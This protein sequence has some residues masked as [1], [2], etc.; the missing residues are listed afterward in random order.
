MSRSF[1]FVVVSAAWMLSALVLS[2]CGE[3]PLD[4]AVD[5]G[6]DLDHSEAIASGGDLIEGRYRIRGD[7]GEIVL[8]AD[9]ALEWQRSA[10]VKAGKAIPARGMQP[11]TIS[12]E[13]RPRYKI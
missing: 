5:D 1:S 12:I 8:D 7:N 6:Y 9:T 2:G 13:L 11:A 10:W 3:A 4:E